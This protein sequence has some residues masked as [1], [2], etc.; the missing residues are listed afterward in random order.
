V[1]HSHFC[2]VVCDST[3]NTQLHQELLNKEIPAMFNLPD[4]VHF[5]SNTIKD[6]VKL[7]YFQPTIT[8]VRGVIKKFHQSHPGITK[9]KAAH[10][11]CGIMKGFDAIGKTQFRTLIISAW[12]VQVNVPVLKKI[13]F[14]TFFQDLAI[15]FHA[16]TQ[17]SFNF[18]QIL[19]YIIKLG[20]PALKALTCL[21]SNE[22]IVGDIYI[23]W[24]AMIWAIKEELA[25]PFSEIP[26]N[27][28]EQVLGILN[29]CH[30]QLFRKGNL[31]TSA[32][33]YLSG[34]Y[35]NPVYLKSDLF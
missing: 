19:G 33:L 32:K 11:I 22:A 20:S 3:G 24:H 29:A 23:F 15:N 7:A 14:L 12:S 5:I 26:V 34:A 18:E 16:G 30:D 2:A 17:S 10:M 31:V 6:I 21:E 25:H 35:L 1:G 27:V 4:I 28:K 13:G 8:T 9:L